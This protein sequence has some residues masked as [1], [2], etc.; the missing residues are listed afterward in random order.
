MFCISCP[1]LGQALW[2]KDSMAFLMSP[3]A[4]SGQ[5]ES[6]EEQNNRPAFPQPTVSTACRRPSDSG[7]HAC[8]AEDVFNLA[9][10]INLIYLDRHHRQT[11]AAR[12][13][14]A[15]HQLAF[16]SQKRLA[17]GPGNQSLWLQALKPGLLT[18]LGTAFQLRARRGAEALGLHLGVTA[19]RWNCWGS[20]PLGAL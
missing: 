10:S 7:R 14:P 11:K 8:Q 9:G 5:T 12:T 17:P 3:L 2:D 1:P 18:A 6:K 13:V 15:A 20:H 4:G 19:L 16:Q